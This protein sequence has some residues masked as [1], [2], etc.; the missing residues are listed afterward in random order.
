MNKQINPAK[1]N[2]MLAKAT[3]DT[4]PF[5]CTCGCIFFKHVVMVKRI[6]AIR[7]GTSSDVIAE[8]NCLLCTNCNKPLSFEKDQ[9]N[10]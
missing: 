2:L 10:A 4:P 6:S 9:P 7:A 1:M 5:A 8:S 3:D